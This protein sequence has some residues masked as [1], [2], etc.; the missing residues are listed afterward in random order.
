MRY[1]SKTFTTKAREGLC[2]VH[3]HLRMH[4]EMDEHE[5]AILYIQALVYMYVCV[6]CSRTRHCWEK[7]KT[8]Q[9][10]VYAAKATN[11]FSGYK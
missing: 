8:W 11:H 2:T 9:M 3:L 1:A 10:V 7:K 5:R 4:P 6:V